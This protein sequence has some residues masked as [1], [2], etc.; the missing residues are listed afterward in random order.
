L[1]LDG[2]TGDFDLEASAP[3]FLIVPFDFLSFSTLSSGLAFFDVE[4][5]GVYQN[6]N[7]NDLILIG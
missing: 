5:L 1:N 2:V 4:A 7:F 6:G 3:I